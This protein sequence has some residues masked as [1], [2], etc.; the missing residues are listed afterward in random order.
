M[1]KHLR[2]QCPEINNILKTAKVQITFGGW[3][4]RNAEYEYFWKKYK[5]GD[6][7]KIFKNYFEY[8][9]CEVEGDTC[10]FGFGSISFKLWDVKILKKDFDKLV[11]EI[12]EYINNL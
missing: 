7:E 2:V 4:N 3:S 11:D 1:V 5:Q 10:G 12:Q 8:S 9:E 6:I